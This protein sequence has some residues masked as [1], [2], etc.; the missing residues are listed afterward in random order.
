MTGFLAKT[1][2]KLY[3]DEK[4]VIKTMKWEALNEIDID[5]LWWIRYGRISEWL[6]KYEKKKEVKQ[7]ISNWIMLL[8]MIGWLTVT[9]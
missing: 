8:L 9:L 1:N 4:W 7:D 6:N 2:K 3:I 5:G